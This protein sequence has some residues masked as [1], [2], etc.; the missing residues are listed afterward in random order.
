MSGKNP[1]IKV[2]WSVAYVFP[3]AIETCSSGE[4]AFEARRFSTHIFFW[5]V[6]V[7]FSMDEVTARQW[8]L[9]ESRMASLC[10]ACVS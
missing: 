8:I 9:I 3:M 1:R 7:L 4:D 5:R 10:G 2:A 6:A